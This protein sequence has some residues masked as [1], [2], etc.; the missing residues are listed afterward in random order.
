M[1]KAARGQ[2]STASL[3]D[4]IL[5]SRRGH[6][7]SGILSLPNEVLDQIGLEVLVGHHTCLPYEECRINS[8]SVAYASICRRC[9]DVRCTRKFAGSSS[10]Y[11]GNGHLTYRYLISI[12]RGPDI[13][14]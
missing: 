13:R 2:T 4:R 8:V 5:S 12:M 10:L 1:F 7:I 11:P 14:S 3:A 6:A 9:T